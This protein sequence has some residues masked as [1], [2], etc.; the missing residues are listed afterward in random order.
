MRKPFRG[1]TLLELLVAMAVLALMTVLLAQI[2]VSTSKSWLG[3][4]ARANNFAKARSMLDLMA[5]DVQSG[6][7]RSDLGAF[8]GS[9][10][11][12]YTRRAGV[13]TNQVRDV[14]LV[15]YYLS[16]STLQRADLAI[17][18]SNNAAS[19]ISFGTTNSLPQL[20]GVTARDAS[21]GVVGFKALFLQQDGTLSAT[22]DPAT[23]R[24]VAIGLAVVDDRTLA[25]LGTTQIAGLQAGFAANTTGT[26]SLKAD[27]EAYLT[28]VNWTNY[29]SDLGRGLKIF[30]RNVLFP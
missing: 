21:P 3:G 30:E 1:F 27:W 29:P 28:N 15:K 18:W 24:G 22:F 25:K 13:S 12:F 14:S 11:S 4:Q 7:F 6:V 2:L 10:M 23:S 8:D 26:N 19:D 17:P 5:R 20:A 9:E 16:N